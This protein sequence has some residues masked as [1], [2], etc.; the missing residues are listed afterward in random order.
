MGLFDRKK[1]R[2]EDMHLLQRVVATGAPDPWYRKPSFYAETLVLTVFVSVLSLICFWGRSSHLP[3]YFEGDR[4]K[5]NYEAEFPFKYQSRCEQERQ[6]TEV[7]EKTEPVVRVAFSQGDPARQAVKNLR[8]AVKL[9]DEDLNAFPPPKNSPAVGGG[10]V[11]AGGGGGADAGP[12]SSSARIARLEKKL[13]E[14]RLTETPDDVAKSL[15]IVAD[16]A[17]HRAGALLEEALGDLAALL[18]RGVRDEKSPRSGRENLDIGQAWRRLD[19]EF[20]KLSGRYPNAGDDRLYDALYRLFNPLCQPNVEIDA[21]A[22]RR[23]VDEAL[24]RVGMP[25]KEIPAGYT[26]L[27]RN[28]LITA[29]VLERWEAYR[30]E[31]AGAV[32]SASRLRAVEESFL[33]AAAVVLLSALFAHIVPPPPGS[34][35]RRVWLAAFMVAVNLALARAFLELGENR[36]VLEFF[37][38]AEVFFWLTPPAFAAI[39]VAVLCGSRLAL[40]SACIV[41]AFCSLMLGR[42]VDVLLTFL[43]SS[44]LG[45][46][47]ARD[48]RKRESVVGAGLLSGLAVMIPAVLVFQVQ[49]QGMTMRLGW[50]VLG[51][52][53]SGLL[54]GILSLGLLPLLER[55]FHVTGAL[56]LIELDTADHELLRTLR[57]VAPGTLN[58]SR[59]VADLA[60]DAA[61]S[62]GADARLCHCASLFH[63]IGKMVK[64][65]YFIENQRGENPHDALKPT[66]SAIII[67]GHVSEGDAIAAHY[68]LPREVRD[69]IRQHHGTDLIRFFYNKARG[70]GATEA[71]FRYDGPRPQTRE[72]GIIMLADGVEAASRALK[73]VSEKSISDLVDNI[74]FTRVREGQLDECPLTTSELRTIRESFKNS[75]KNMYHQRVAYPVDPASLSASAPASSPAP[76]AAAAPIRN[77]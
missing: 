39:V 33:P 57:I 34:R 70:D 36:E 7:R 29:D 3:I 17:G 68:R 24:A 9:L 25:L 30:R 13:A 75:L 59:N 5:V 72:A 41:S 2:R 1:H 67:K 35:R 42:S 20:R 27:E 65:E 18:R 22:T 58:H 53:L 77:P 69:V 64:P 48:V 47:V 14:N 31:A 15:V 19:N 26:L 73:D 32:R 63:D 61:D 28:G 66:V 43:L 12:A 74:V 50:L 38:G 51:C 55:I 49:T 56:K 10:D 40:L 44:F 52:A 6:L 21:A 8:E 37:K 46:F 23:R 62:I 16:I 4:S 60:R 76:A 71:Q 11:P 54:T 45:V